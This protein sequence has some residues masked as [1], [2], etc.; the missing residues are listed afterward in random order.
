[1]KLVVAY[2]GTDFRGFAR[3]PD[4]RTVAGELTAALE[5]IT[6]QRIEVTGA[7]RTDSGVHAWGQ[8]VTVDVPSGLDPFRLQNSLNSMLNPEIAVRSAKFVAHDFDARFSAAWR[9]YR[10]TIVNGV[11]MDPLRSRFS[12]WV[13]PPLDL[14]RLMLAADVFIGE[15]DFASFCRRRSDGSTTVRRVF[16]SRWVDEGD[17]VLR[18]E[19]RA[20]AFCWRM[21]RSIVGTLVDVGMGRRKPGEIMGILAAKDRAEAGQVAPP[22]GLCLWEVGYGSRPE[23]LTAT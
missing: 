1:L 18:Y 8:V 20:T 11:V 5:R 22:E 15:H 7:G 2:D 4:Q 13:E 10:Y 6:Q 9:A 12:W 23:L 16:E 17:G 19:I 21:V 3:Q 14:H